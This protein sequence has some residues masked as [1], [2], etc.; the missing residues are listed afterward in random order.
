MLNSPRLLFLDEP[1]TGLDPDISMKTRHL[2]GKIHKEQ[3]ITVLLSTHYM[4]EAEMLCDKIAFLRKGEIVA[5]DTPQ[6]LKNH[7]GLGE[8]VTVQ[9][10]GGLD[11][12]ELKRVP[13]VLSVSAF[14]GKVEIV[15]DR[16]AENLDRIVKL[17]AGAKIL[18][19]SIKEPDLEDVFIELAR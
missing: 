11:T 4:P 3:N 18:D 17:F 2:I 15:I 1:T 16:N 7:L 13:G 5:L 12:A 19:I 8:K 6:N 10:L 9:F 14:P